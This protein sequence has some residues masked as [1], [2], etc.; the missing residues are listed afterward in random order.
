M[1]AITLLKWTF[2]TV[3]GLGLLWLAWRALTST[4]LFQAIILFVS[5]GLL[6]TLAWVRLDAPDIALAE[7]AI[8]A[9]LTGALL[10]STLARL[11]TAE[12]ENTL[13]Q[14]VQP[15]SKPQLV[16]WLLIIII[17]LLLAGLGY[18]ILDLPPYFEGLSGAVAAN[19]DASGANNPVTAVL[20]NFR[21]YDTMLEIIVLLMALLG[22]WSLG[23]MPPYTDKPAGAVLDTFSRFLV[24]VF[25]LVGAYL[26]WIGT[27]AP[28]GAF[29]AGSVLGAAAVLLILSDWRLRPTF[30]QRTLKL[31][32]ISGSSAFITI[33][34]LTTLYEGQLLAY[35]ATYAGILILF[36][37]SLAT[38]SIG[39]T[40]GALFLREP[41][42]YMESQ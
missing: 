33:G 22:A 27:S 34:L 19:L 1:E 5:F 8:G 23:G 25:I 9:G 31:A 37:E 13:P 11:Q 36:L 4:D 16:H 12:V 3:L 20:L 24:P 15:S 32:L 2:D 21:G 14:S 42:K 38:I 41:V 28:G 40:L 39:V 35:P 7:A 26:L 10:L 6:M 29:Q 18:A 17:P 30:I